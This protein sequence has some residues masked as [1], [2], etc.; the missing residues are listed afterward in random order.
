MTGYHVGQ[1]IE[2]RLGIGRVSPAGLDPAALTAHFSP[3][4]RAHSGG[5]RLEGFAGRLAAKY[6]VADV[7][8]QC[9]HEP[10]L[11]R[12]IQVLPVPRLACRSPLLCDRGHPPAVG[13]EPGSGV[14]R[15]EGLIWIDV[16]VSHEAAQAFAVALA[17]FA[18]RTCDDGP[19]D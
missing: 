15:C 8:G 9:P 7:L 18:A 16:S 5:R 1:Q 2:L 3:L 4:E 19:G 11:L 17:V 13:F 14:A 12:E 6:A 10:G